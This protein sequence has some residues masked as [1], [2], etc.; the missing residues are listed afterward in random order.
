MPG[1]RLKEKSPCAF[2]IPEAY[3][4]PRKIVY[5]NRVYLPGDW[6]AAEG[7]AVEELDRPAATPGLRRV[8]DRCLDATAVLLQQAR[9]LPR[10]LPSRRLAMESAAIIRLAEKLTAM[11]RRR[12]PLAE[13]V[14]LSKRGFLLFAL[15]GVGRYWLGR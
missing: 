15:M 3:P 8:L 1:S 14:T 2:V 7:S 9:P 4:I 5:L 11:L 6:L 10:I 13:R 12:D